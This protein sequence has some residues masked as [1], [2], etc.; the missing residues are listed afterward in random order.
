MPRVISVGRL[1]PGTKAPAIDSTPYANGQTFLQGAPL[2]LTAGV[3]SECAG[4]PT[5]IYAFAGEPAGSKAGYLAANAPTVVTGRKQETSNYLVSA[6]QE[7][8]GLLVNGSA[9]LVAPT[10]AMKGV[11]T[12][13]LSKQTIGGIATWVVDQAA[14][15]CLSITDVDVDAG[16]VYFKVLVANRQVI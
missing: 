16:L 10:A 9:V 1:A 5:S 12:Y 4:N 6:N 11:V 3:A 15:P 13:G 8:T 2:V 7:F 14:T